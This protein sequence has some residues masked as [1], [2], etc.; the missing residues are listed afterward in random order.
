MISSTH[1]EPSKKENIDQYI[2]YP[3]P[4]AHLNNYKDITLCIL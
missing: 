1:F 3:L 2:V 4:P